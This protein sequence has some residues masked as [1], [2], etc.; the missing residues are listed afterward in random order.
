MFSLWGWSTWHLNATTSPEV[1]APNPEF[2]TQLHPRSFSNLHCLP[3]ALSGSR[4]EEGQSHSVCPWTGKE[5]VW[6]NPPFP[7]LPS[8]RPCGDK[9]GE[10][11]GSLSTNRQT[12]IP[13]SQSMENLLLWGFGPTPILGVTV[14]AKQCSLKSAWS[15]FLHKRYL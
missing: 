3:E 13:P 11:M 10:W 2:P 12:Y 7:G 14:K 15:G 6:P 9:V 5:F 1:S 8:F 4:E